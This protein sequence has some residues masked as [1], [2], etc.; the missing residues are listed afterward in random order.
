MSTGVEYFDTVK[1]AMMTFES[2]DLE[3]ARGF[4]ESSLGA[5][6]TYDAVV[7]LSASLKR[8]SNLNKA[9]NKRLEGNYDSDFVK[10]EKAI[11]VIFNILDEFDREYQMN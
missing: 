7:R 2:V 5:K 3:E 11:N 4:P 8:G 6:N 10:M 9:V 1:D